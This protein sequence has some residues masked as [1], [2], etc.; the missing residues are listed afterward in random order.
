KAFFRHF[1][2]QSYAKPTFD[3]KRRH[4]LWRFWRD[5]P[6][7]GEF[8]V[9]DRS[10][11]GRVLVE[12]VQGYASNEQWT[13]AYDEIVQFERSL[14][15]EGVEVIKFWLHISPEEQLRRFNKRK[16]DPMR[17]WKLTEEDWRNR[18][19]ADEYTA[20]VDDMFLYTDH[21]VAPWTVISGEQKRWA[22]VQI[23]ENVVARM[24]KALASFEHPDWGEDGYA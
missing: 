21:A 13:R 4:F 19:R 11:F 2:V 3:E 18:E 23:V 10:W 24:E 22:R 5:I 12:R 9:F 1:T 20:A 17:A 7:L 6:G 15:L 14:V 16:K 8:A